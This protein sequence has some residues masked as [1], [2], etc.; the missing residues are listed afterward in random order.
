MAEHESKSPSGAQDVEEIR[1]K[2]KSAEPVPEKL[3]AQLGEPNPFATILKD[4]MGES[5]IENHAALLGD[6]RFSHPANDVQVARMV[7]ELQQSYGNAH[8]Q[9]VMGRIQAKL[10]INPPDDAYE[11]EADRMADA[12]MQTSADQI[13]RQPEEEEEE[14]L[15]MKPASEIQ[16]QPLE[17]EEELLQAKP[18]SEIQRQPI[19]EEEEYAKLSDI[20]KLPGVGSQYG[21]VPP[22]TESQ[23]AKLSDV[24]PP[25]GSQYAKTPEFVHPPGPATE[26]PGKAGPLWWRIRVSQGM[27]A[28][29]TPPES[30][31]AES[32]SQYAMTPSWVT[33]TPQYGRPGSVKPGSEYGK[34]PPKPQSAK[35][36]EE[37]ARVEDFPHVTGAKSQYGKAPRWVTATPRKSEATTKPEEEELMMK[38][39]SEIQRQPEEEEEEEL[40]MKPAS[41]IQRQPEEEEE[42]ELLQTKVV[43]SRVPEVSENL[44]MRINTARGNGQPLSDSVRPSLEP[45]LGHDFSEVRI[46]TDAEADKLSRQLGAEAF[47]TGH[48]VF[49]REGAYQPDSESGKRLIVHELAHVVQQQA[50]PAVQRQ[51]ET[52]VK[53]EGPPLTEEEKEEEAMLAARAGTWQAV[54]VGSLENLKRLAEE[55]EYE[56]VLDGVKQVIDVILNLAMGWNLSEGAWGQINVV[57][58]TLI[59]A[60]EQA[61]G[62]TTGG[63]GIPGYISGALGTA[64][65]VALSPKL[66][67]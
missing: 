54:V 67:K 25:L 4:P 10:S 59:G 49:F 51:V 21:R 18:A 8:L 38:P 57:V 61:T 36:P 14:E 37:W 26:V 19:E 39:A 17:E 46:H 31:Y 33:A 30:I 20:P 52:T 58:D 42:E 55:E 50:V 63:K 15:M 24:A 44:E 23:Y 45:R 32:K 41:E 22:R 48:D 66:L 47:T 16:R 60:K 28:P 27:E 1:R 56:A 6:E 62:V 40:Q 35:T 43:G 2:K 64:I 12:V 7:T 53:P 5:S 34:I 65:P 9:Q 11:R 3:K 13:Q 29:G